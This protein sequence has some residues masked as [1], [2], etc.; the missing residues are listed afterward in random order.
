MSKVLKLLTLAGLVVG[1]AL[2]GAILL[3]RVFPSL[4]IVSNG[5]PVL[6]LGCFFLFLLAAYSGPKGAAPSALVLLLFNGAM[7]YPALTT[8][9]QTAEASRAP[10]LKVATLN[11]RQRNL[12]PAKAVEWIEQ[13]DPDVVVLQ[14]MWALNKPPFN[15]LLDRYPY[16]VGKQ[17]VVLLS[18][19]PIESKGQITRAGFEVWNE[20]LARWAQVTVN[21]V[22]VEILAVHPARPFYPDLQQNDMDSLTRFVQSR[23]GPL[24]VAGDFNQTP[25]TQSL[26]RFTEITGLGRLNTYR[27]T[28]PMRREGT[29]IVPLLPIDNIFIS[30][31]LAVIDTQFSPDVG[32]DHRGVAADLAL[33]APQP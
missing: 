7:L 25:W 6:V 4:D 16:Q 1:L 23:H 24:V 18:K 19:Y 17:S 13:L 29:Q 26:Q 22:P 15:A 5:L 11:V 12:E 14:E 10:L 32:S 28:W 30:S 20:T 33:A 8:T 31:Q 3:A 9:A 2:T 27:P 21:G